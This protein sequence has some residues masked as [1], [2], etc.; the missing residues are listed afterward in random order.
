MGE[1]LVSIDVQRWDLSLTL[2]DRAAVRDYLIGKGAAPER[3]ATAAL[4]IDVPLGVTK[5]GALI[6]GRVP[7]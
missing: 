5:R 3:A 6:W 4:D 7:T 1:H 2:P